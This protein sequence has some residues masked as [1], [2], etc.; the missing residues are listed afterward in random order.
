VEVITAATATAWSG[1]VG[2]P[3]EGL[4]HSGTCHVRIKKVAL[5]DDG[6]FPDTKWEVQSSAC[7]TGV[8]TPDAEAADM[9]VFLFTDTI[10]GL[11]F[12]TSLVNV[13]TGIDGTAASSFRRYCRARGFHLSRVIEQGTSIANV[14]EELLAATNSTVIWVDGVLTAVP[15]DDEASSTSDFWP[16][17]ATY[18]YTPVTS[19]VAVGDDDFADDED[20]VEVT[21]E[22]RSRVFSV[23]PV[24]YTLRKND[25]GEVTY[26]T[27]HAEYQSDVW[28]SAN[29]LRRAET[30][31]LTPWVLSE[32]HAWF[33][34][35]LSAQRSMYH[36][37]RYTFRVKPRL[38]LLA[39]GDF[40]DL[41]D[42]QLGIA[43]VSCRAETAEEDEDGVIEIT[44][45]EW[46]RGTTKAFSLPTTPPGGRLSAGTARSLAAFDLQNVPDSSVETRLVDDGAIIG[47]KFA[48]DSIATS[49]YAYTGTLGASD[50]KA[51]TG[52][53]MRVNASPGSLPAIL[54]SPPGI[55]VGSYTLDAPVISALSALA[56]SGIAV[57]DRVWYRGNV[58]SNYASG[59]PRIFDAVWTRSTVV[60]IGERVIGDPSP[61]GYPL[62]D[63]N[64][65]SGNKATKVYR[66]ITA[67]TTSATGNG[68][69]GTAA[70]I[71]DGTVHWAY[72]SAADNSNVERI[73]VAARLS[74]W[75]QAN[76]T[77]AHIIRI[78]VSPHG[79][80][81]NLDAMRYLSVQWFTSAGAALDITNHV[82]PDRNYYNPTTDFTA[83]NESV[84]DAFLAIRDATYRGAAGTPFL[85]AGYL[86]IIPI[87]AFGAGAGRDFGPGPNVVNQAYAAGGLT[88]PTQGTPPPPSGGGG[89]GACPAPDVGVLLADGSHRPAGLLRSGD[90][91]WTVP[92]DGAPGEREVEAAEVV[93][94]SDRL[95][96]S[97]GDGARLVYSPRHLVMTPGGWT[98]AQNL[99]AGD[100]MLTLC[101]DRRVASPLAP[102]SGSPRPGRPM[103]PRAGS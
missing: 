57:T 73:L 71:T 95:L 52:A 17:H 24:D 10:H 81:D 59:T 96:L 80:F 18:P 91:I 34:A 38:A 100:R 28:S 60:A 99:R 97:L 53:R 14:I 103:S 1:Y 43:D 92:Q 77:Q 27:N 94:G 84:M 90:R 39:Q 58:D 19:S 70:D 98:S 26:A 6:S 61:A 50:E 16:G 35:Y 33:V 3:S 32:R 66:C 74:E 29:G 21:R 37:A 102:W 47:S 63:Y 69:T 20:P 67:G 78:V 88:I 93:H 76:V 42:S 23:Y 55:K 13:E 48:A 64:A 82:A 44:A 41:T 89:G 75:W 36:R 25:S 2:T 12:S 15:L 30:L 54:A 11:G 46:P 22:P 85:F 65:A 5:R 51:T 8:S 87:N 68:P 86:R 49:D 45:L 79:Q 31:D 7:V 4:A 101:G 40:V 83:G 9:L 72:V 56:R 62:A